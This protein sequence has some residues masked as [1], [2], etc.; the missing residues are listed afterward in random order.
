MTSRDEVLAASVAVMAAFGYRVNPQPA[1]IRRPMAEM[2]S[3]V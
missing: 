2:V 1:K 3:W